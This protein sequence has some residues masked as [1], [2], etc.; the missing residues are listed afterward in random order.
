MGKINSFRDLVA[1]QKGIELVKTIY[2]LTAK[3]PDDEKFGLVSQVRRAAVSVP[4]NIAEGYARRSRADYLRFLNI[5]RGSTDEVETQLIVSKE[6]G[7]ANHRGLGEAMSST[8]EV[9]RLLGRLIRSIEQATVRYPA[10]S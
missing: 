5:A 2:M 7:F 6:L 3:F 9:Q 4:S 8:K 10:L 1:W